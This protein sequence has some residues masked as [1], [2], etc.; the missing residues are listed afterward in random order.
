[1]QPNAHEREML[2]RIKGIQGEVE[3][4]EKIVARLDS[5]VGNIEGGAQQ[6]FNPTEL[7]VGPTGDIR[8]EPESKERPLDI[9]KPGPAS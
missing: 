8:P 6:L 5:R 2:E 9:S 3:K 1:M 4:L 7:E